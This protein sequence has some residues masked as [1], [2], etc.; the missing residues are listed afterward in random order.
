M[1]LEAILLFMTSLLL[2]RPFAQ[3]LYSTKV[4]ELLS[5]PPREILPSTVCDFFKLFIQVIQGSNN[6]EKYCLHCNDCLRGPVDKEED[7]R[8]RG[9]EFKPP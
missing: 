8:F 5:P 1:Y 7:Y 2:Q 9:W 3:F 6:N 4:H